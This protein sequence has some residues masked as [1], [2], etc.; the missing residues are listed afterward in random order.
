MYMKMLHSGKRVGCVITLHIPAELSLIAQVGF[1]D[2]QERYNPYK[3]PVG[4]KCA[5]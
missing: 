3:V 1:K 5:P 2:R 4:S